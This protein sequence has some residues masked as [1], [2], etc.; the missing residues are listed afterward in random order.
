MAQ[1]PLDLALER[2]SDVPLGTQ[3]AWKLRGAIAAGSLR[4]GD[5]LPAV[6]ELAATAGV[7]VNTV[8]AVYARLAAQD[9][10]VSEQG[11]GTFVS[12][13]GD[14]RANLGELVERAARDARR[15]HVDPRELA[16]VLYA[17]FDAPLSPGEAPSLDTEAER[18]RA[19]RAEVEAL[20]HELAGLEPL[21]GRAPRS[22]ALAPGGG[23]RLVS[24]RE[25]EATRDDLARR[26]SERRQE[27]RAARTAARSRPLE[28]QAPARASSSAWPELRLAL[29]PSPRA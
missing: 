26:A 22:E 3:L 18:R 2:D 23:A 7:N 27:L 11:R 1:Q 13:A 5:R 8:R 9:V 17:R 28:A 4:T 10:I 12:G 21:G 14:T 15:H 24:A 6:R 20:E 16:A 29:S 25:L 19:L